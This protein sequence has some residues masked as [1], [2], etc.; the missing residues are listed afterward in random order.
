MG[1]YKEI[2]SSGLDIAK[3]I[4]DEELDLDEDNLTRSFSECELENSISRCGSMSNS[5]RQRGGSVAS[6]SS[7]KEVYRVRII[8]AYTLCLYFVVHRKRKIS[9]LLL[10][11]P[12][13]RAECLSK[14]IGN[15]SGRA[16]DSV[17]SFG[18]HSRVCSPNFYSVDL[19]IG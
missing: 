16:V 4:E 8:F 18:C 10:K 6:R 9:R 13:P 15:T 14:F 5:T 7:A 2:S 19:I 11:K 3:T 17:P 12:V 1:T